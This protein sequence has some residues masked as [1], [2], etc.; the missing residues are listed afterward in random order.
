MDD[1]NWEYETLRIDAGLFVVSNPASRTKFSENPKDPASELLSFYRENQSAK[2]FILPPCSKVTYELANRLYD[3]VLVMD[4]NKCRLRIF[5][6]VVPTAHSTCINSREDLEQELT[7]Y[8]RYLEHGQI[9]VYFPDRYRKLDSSLADLLECTLLS[10]QKKC[11]SLAANRSLKRWHGNT[12]LIL[13]LTSEPNFLSSFPILDAPVVIVG[14]GPSLDLTVSTL[15]EFSDKAYIIACDGAL[16]TLLKSKIIPDFIVSM[17]D[18]LMSWRFFAGHENELKSVPLILNLKSNHALVKN[19]PGP[20]Y[21][22]GSSESESWVES[23]I[24]GFASLEVGRCVG[25]MAFNF[26]IASKASEIIMTGF[27]LAFRNE[28][29]HPKDMPIK[30]FEGMAVP[31]LCEVSGAYEKI[32]Q[33][34]MTMKLFLEDFEWMIQN[35]SLQIVDA[36]EGGALKKGAKRQSLKSSLEFNVCL[37]KDI[38]IDYKIYNSILLNKYLED[39][40]MNSSSVGFRELTEPFTSYLLQGSSE[41]SE[42]QK[43][44]DWSNAASFLLTVLNSVSQEPANS[45]VFLGNESADDTLALIGEDIRVLKP[46]DLIESLKAIDEYGLRK[47]YTVNGKFPPDLLQLRSIDVFDIKTDETVNDW[48]RNLWLPNYHVLSLDE[49]ESF[50]GEYLPADIPLKSIKNSVLETGYGMY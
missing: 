41:V 25:H 8:R 4:T 6:A 11:A 9:R 48:E 10:Y 37:L 44:D 7:E 5:D 14:A 31:N 18:T 12:N 40:K 19:Y 29:F 46:N 49:V 33:T 24:K 13:N 26:A 39:F 16:Q 20:V 3:H 43:Q 38:S 21:L 27:D 50:W 42:E 47:I 32:V 2:V 15:K 1:D 36:T 22:T 34:D 35:T 45:A 30:Y 17:E 23:F 28:S